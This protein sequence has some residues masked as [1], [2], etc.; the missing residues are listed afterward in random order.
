MELRRGVWPR[1]SSAASIGGETKPVTSSV[2]CEPPA[3]WTASAGW[4]GNFGDLLGPPDDG[5]MRAETPVPRRATI[6]LDLPPDVAAALEKRAKE[7][8]RYAH[9]EAARLLRRS[10]AR[11]LHGNEPEAQP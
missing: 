2:T 1:S 7:N 8:D 10:L 9:Q 6:R 3:E 5:A 11:D 4:L